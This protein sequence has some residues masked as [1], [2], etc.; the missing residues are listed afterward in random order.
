[1]NFRQLRYF[2]VLADELHFHRAA[3]RLHITQAPLSLTIQALERELGTVLFVRTRRRVSLTES[4]AMLR[5]DA[6]AILDRVEQSRAMIRDLEAGTI[7]QI[8]VAV[9]P[10]SSLLPFFPSLISAFRASH[11][12]VRIVMKEM[13]S[14]DQIRGLQERDIDVGIMRNP[15]KKDVSDLS[16][17]K[18]LSDP[19]VVAMDRRHPLNKRSSLKLADLRDEAFISYPR[20]S[21]IA[22]YEQVTALFAARGFAPN[23]VQEVQ[24][25]TTLIGLAATGFGV[26][27]VPSGLTHI[28][29]PNIVYK[30]LADPDATTEIHLACREGEPSII[31]S[32]FRRMAQSIAGKRRRK[33]PTEATK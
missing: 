31:I 29:V 2:A 4:G 18:L 32:T 28:R 27:V 23:I 33:S 6:R 15:P 25:V 20:Q 7:G 10:A 17:V 22:I 16:F 8:R 9:T 26:A 11:P 14:K 13:T 19:L 1:M 3:E 24:E 21:G 12:R 5:A 30:R